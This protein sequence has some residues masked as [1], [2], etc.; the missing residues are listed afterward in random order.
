M[1]G[2]VD[3]K[4]TPD[5]RTNSLTD[6]EQKYKIFAPQLSVTRF[7]KRITDFSLDKVSAFCVSASLQDCISVS[8]LMLSIV[9]LPLA[10]EISFGCFPQQSREH[11][12]NDPVSQVTVQQLISTFGFSLLSLTHKQTQQ[13]SSLCKLSVKPPLTS[14]QSVGLVSVCLKLPVVVQNADPSS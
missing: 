6:G 1:L 13:H 12:Q 9:E 8:F 3:C 5:F 11:L 14:P 10:L 2:C 7:I 4:L